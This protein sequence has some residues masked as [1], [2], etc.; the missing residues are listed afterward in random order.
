MTISCS[1][2]DSVVIV[3]FYFCESVQITLQTIV[4]LI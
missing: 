1:R 2:H 3:W 4:Q